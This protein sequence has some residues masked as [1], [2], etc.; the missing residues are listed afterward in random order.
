[1]YS[2]THT[3]NLLLDEKKKITAELNIKKSE[4]AVSD[5]TIKQ[6]KHFT[7]KKDK[8]HKEMKE[9]HDKNHETIEVLT[10]EITDMAWKKD[11]EERRLADKQLLNKQKAITTAL[12]TECE[13]INNDLLIAESRIKDL[14][15]QQ[16]NSNEQIQDILTEKR[17]VDKVNLEME[18]RL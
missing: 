6:A 10:K 3:K 5:R 18:H 14:E 2:E 16:K 8:V 12:T 11:T 7:G 9:A 15:R 1:M 13:Q 17:K 4:N